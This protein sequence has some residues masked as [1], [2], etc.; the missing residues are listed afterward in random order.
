MMNRKLTTIRNAASLLANILREIFDE[1]SY[2]R[3][4]ARTGLANSPSAYAEFLRQEAHLRERRARC[5]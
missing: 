5:C 4:L 3:F 1:N 2:A